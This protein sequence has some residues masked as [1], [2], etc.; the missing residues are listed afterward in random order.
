MPEFWGMGIMKEALPAVCEFGFKQLDLHRIEAL[1]ETD[2]LS[3]I[4]LI[5]QLNFNHEG[6]MKDCEIK[7]GKYLNLAIYAL[8]N[9]K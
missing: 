5:S 8:F 2:N 4:N 1:I 9:S 6:T 3:S 7:N